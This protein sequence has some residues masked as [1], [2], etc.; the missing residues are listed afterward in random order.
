MVTEHGWGRII[1]VRTFLGCCCSRRVVP[2]SFPVVLGNFDVTSP[3]K[4]VGKIRTRFQGFSGNSDRANCPGCGKHPSCSST[5]KLI[6]GKTSRKNGQ[7]VLWLCC[8][9][10]WIGMLCVLPPTKTNLATLFVARQVR[11]WVVKRTT[12][13][14][15][16]F[17]SNFTKQV[18][19]F[20]RPFYCSFKN[21]STQKEQNRGTL[22][23][24]CPSAFTLPQSA[25]K[26]LTRTLQSLFF[27]H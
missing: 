20:C 15:N 21:K 16:S 8:K 14:L 2:A 26:H 23:K 1:W 9:R 3:V 12:S 13:L 10:S 18:A 25:R 17:C 24:Q 11:T 22:M 5:A 7:L 6:Y 4:L 27:D 19:H